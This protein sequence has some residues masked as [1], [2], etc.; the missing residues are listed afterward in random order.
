MLKG[1]Y[2]ILDVKEASIDTPTLERRARTLLE[3]Q[4]CC[5][6]LRAKHLPAGRLVACAEILQAM[7]ASTGVWFCVNDRL[8][9]ALAAKTDMVHLGQ[10]DLPLR[11]ALAIRGT[12]TRPL[13]GISTHT[14]EEAEQA[15]QGGADC[16][17]FGP[18][19]ST[20][21][22]QDAGAPL[23]L[24]LLAEVTARV[25]LP[26]VAIGGITLD[27]LPAVVEAGA[28]AAAVI[29]AVDQSADPARAGRA[30]GEA[31]RASRRART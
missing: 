20:R 1:Y 24:S 29:A 26:V 27:N 17:G 6:Q 16:L 25:T 9:V 21:T 30:I 11:H 7:S 31:F 15:A 22:K 19:F 23:G 2:A 14:V 28:A 12:A 5:L 18:V 3:G 4:P 8:D 13:L 10:G